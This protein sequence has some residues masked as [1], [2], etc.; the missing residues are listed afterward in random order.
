MKPTDLAI[1]L[2]VAILFCTSLGFAQQQSEPPEEGD[3]IRQRMEWFYNQRAYPLKH[4]PA[5]A[6]LRALKQLDQMLADEA[7][8]PNSDLSPENAFDDP[9]AASSSTRW[10]LI[11]PEPTS[12]HY[13][14]PTVAGRVAALAVD[15][16]NANVVYA[17]AA[18]G[19]VWKTTDGGVHWTPLTDAQPSLAV[20]SIAIDPLNHSIIYVGTGEENYSNDSYYGEG[21]LKSTNGG[22]SWTQIKGPFAGPLNELMGGALI[23]AIAVDPGNSAVILVGVR[24]YLG[25]TGVYR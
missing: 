24:I 21:I 5:G 23:G 11:G 22:T 12:T 4:I 19:G 3:M 1:R 16:T 7:A 17:G 10:T 9:Y 13:S 6:R 2:T 8:T 14:S 15:P 18:G 20:G 25:T